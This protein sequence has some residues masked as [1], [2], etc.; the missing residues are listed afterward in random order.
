MVL[1]APQLQTFPNAYACFW[2][3]NGPALVTKLHSGE[4]PTRQERIFMV[5]VL[6]EH[7]M[8]NAAT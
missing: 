8:E 7:L 6:V 1:T 5:N 4:K 3:V 2:V